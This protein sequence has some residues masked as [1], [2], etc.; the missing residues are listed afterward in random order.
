MQ[1][2]SRR[3]DSAPRARDAVGAAG[4]DYWF[5]PALITKIAMSASS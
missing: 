5:P 2:F 4:G 3:Q 1:G